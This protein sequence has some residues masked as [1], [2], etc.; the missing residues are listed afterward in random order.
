M[1]GTEHLGTRFIYQELFITA[2]TSWHWGYKEKSGKAL[3]LEEL[4][5]SQEKR[6]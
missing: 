2:G 3:A 6:L 4:L 1:P 5:F